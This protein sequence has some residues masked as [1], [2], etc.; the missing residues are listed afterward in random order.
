MNIDLNIRSVMKGQI[1]T[2]E[3]GNQFVRRPVP[4]DGIIL[5]TEKNTLFIPV[6]LDALKTA[7]AV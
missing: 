4:S 5:E 6:P 2:Y 1:A 7:L 3:D